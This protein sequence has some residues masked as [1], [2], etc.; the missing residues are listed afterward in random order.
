MTKLD[1]AREWLASGLIKSG[2]RLAEWVRPAPLGN[3]LARLVCPH[4]YVH[5]AIGDGGAGGARW[6]R[7]TLCGKNTTDPPFMALRVAWARCLDWYEK[8]RTN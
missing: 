5:Q 2:L 1:S 4:L 3:K 8:R 7:C 6:P